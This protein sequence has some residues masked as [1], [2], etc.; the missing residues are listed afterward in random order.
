MY[1]KSFEIFHNKEERKRLTHKHKR[2]PD[3]QLVPKPLSLSPST[4]AVHKLSLP[5]TT[6][7]VCH[8]TVT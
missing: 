6:K 7:T 5:T 4:C 1:L 3:P 8:T 2:I